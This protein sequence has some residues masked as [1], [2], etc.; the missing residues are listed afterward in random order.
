MI[1][2]LA[3]CS[4][5]FLLMA[6]SNAVVPVLDVF[7]IGPEEQGLVFSAYFFGATLMVLPAGMAADRFSRRRLMQVG[8]GVSLLAGLVIAVAPN[9]WSIVGARFVEGVATGLFV[10]AGL[11]H[12][13]SQADNGRSSGAFMASLN[14]GLLAGL[15]LTGLLVELTGLR[16]A[17]VLAFASLSL[18]PFLFSFSFE[19]E[20]VSGFHEP[21]VRLGP[22]L[23]QYHWL[24]YASLVMFGAGGAV[25]GLYPEFSNADP[26]LLGV[27]I[28]LQNVATIVAVVVVSRLAIEPIP[29]IR[30]CGG[31]MA[32][33]VAVSFLTPYGFAL[34]GAAGGAVQIAT[35]LFL[36]RTGEPAGL[37]AGLFSTASYAGMAILPPLASVA[38]RWVGYTMTFGLLVLVSI[39]VAFT[40]QRCTRCRLD[41]SRLQG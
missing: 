21:L 20:T 13:N 7:A 36:S 6:L 23:S 1:R 9:V 25:T 16:E 26:G 38:A 19:Q 5:I 15:I 41:P 40:V 32:L 8:L 34:I 4:G 27:Q 22:M 33:A 18:L 31:F 17:G 24:F 29:L 30:A 3:V 10:S 2:R 11:A 37:G 12:V 28:A 35:L 14:A 39:T